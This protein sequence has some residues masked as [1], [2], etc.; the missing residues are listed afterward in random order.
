M[1]LKKDKLK[2][3]LSSAINAQPDATPPH[4]DARAIDSITKNESA[5]MGEKIEDKKG[6]V[7]AKKVKPADTKKAEKIEKE[8][9]QKSKNNAPKK[10]KKGKEVEVKPVRVRRI[11]TD[12]KNGLTLEQV[13][14]RNEKG[15]NNIMPN[16]NVK[17]YRSIFVENIC[18]F[19]NILCIAIFM[20]IA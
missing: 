12:F 5:K 10:A 6:F 17:T 14:D 8:L 7:N 1:A 18:T 9:T 4:T 13:A 2:S 16:T 20:P 11:K 19:F 3:Q 15:L